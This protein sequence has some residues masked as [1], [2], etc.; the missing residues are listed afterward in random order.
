MPYLP[1]HSLI[2]R[3]FNKLQIQLN[4]VMSK[5]R[6]TSFH[7]NEERELA[8]RDTLAHMDV[9]I[10]C[11][12]PLLSEAKIKK[13]SK[14]KEDED[15]GS[16]RFSKEDSLHVVVM[17]LVQLTSNLRAGRLLIDHGFV[18]EF[19]V[20]CRLLQETV[21]DIFFF[22]YENRVG[23]ESSLHEKFRRTFYTEDVD[24]EGNWQ[25]PSNWVGRK[26]IREFVDGCLTEDTSK[27]LGT[28]ADS[29]DETMKGLYGFGSGYVHGRVSKAMRLYD[30]EE[31]KFLTNGLYDEE[32]LS[33]ELKRFWV[34]AI[35][36]I[37]CCGSIGERWGA[38]EEYFS[39]TRVLAELLRK[40]AGLGD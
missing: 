24:E 40:I 31:N 17:K 25:Q 36:A 13:I 2:L 34:I 18:Y 33:I 29:L 14:N 7:W 20:M 30:L 19:G 8:F 39:N 3:C 26:K 35:K 22:V 21:E 11:L 23:K 10:D 28:K 32:Y 37:A 27:V 38:P 4:R 1:C 16:I 6:R 15:L 9:T 5:K 12:L